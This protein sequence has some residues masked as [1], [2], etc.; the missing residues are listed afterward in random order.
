MG[1]SLRRLLVAGWLLIC[2]GT[3]S[4]EAAPTSPHQIFAPVLVFHHVK[5]FLPGDNAIE[6]GLTVPPE[7]FDAELRYLRAHRYHTVSAYALVRALLSGRRLPSRPV[8]VTFDDGYSDVYANVFP[9][10]RRYHLVATFFIVP[11]FLGRPR[12]LSWR[13]VLTMSRHGMDIEAHTMT[14]PDLTVVSPGQRVSEVA[15]SRTALERRLHRPVLIFA[16]P[17]G[18]YNQAVLETVKRSGFRAAFTTRQGWLERS[19][20]LLTLPRVYVDND[21]SIQIFAGRLT[22]DPAALAADPL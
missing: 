2:F 18:A 12:Y 20:S 14:H 8:V 4:T 22:A 5:A 19:D 1:G 17:Y 10:L 9:A 3:S 7:Q 11:G 15:G 6:R 21:D 16:Y 13:Q